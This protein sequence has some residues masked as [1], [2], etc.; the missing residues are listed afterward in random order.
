MTATLAM[1]VLLFGCEK[2]EFP[3]NANTEIG[4][5]PFN[6]VLSE[7]DTRSTIS[8]SNIDFFYLKIDQEG[9]DFD[10]M[11]KAERQYSPAAGGSADDYKLHENPTGTWSKWTYSKIV[12]NDGGAS[13]TFEPMTSPMYFYDVKLPLTYTAVK[14]DAKGMDIFEY[15]NS[16]VDFK[17]SAL[18]ISVQNANSPTELYANDILH[19]KNSGMPEKGE[20]DGNRT[21]NFYVIPIFMRHCLKR[22]TMNFEFTGNYVDLFENYTVTGEFAAI[23]HKALVKSFTL[24]A[25]ANNPLDYEVDMMINKLTNYSLTTTPNPSTLGSDINFDVEDLSI[26]KINGKWV[27]RCQTLIA[28]HQTHLAGQDNDYN[29]AFDLKLLPIFN[30]N[31]TEKTYQIVNSTSVKTIVDSTPDM[32]QDDFNSGFLNYG[33]QN[34]LVLNYTITENYN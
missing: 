19:I 31:D 17:N 18:N 33:M 34:S 14:W 26:T 4:A 16:K 32:T 13:F 11:I 23:G 21:D 29:L 22:M 6:F 30:V 3:G 7:A 8:T 25:Y 28:S 1:M 15:T 20:V 9:E 24:R 5:V 12:S 27:L 10:Y 2:N